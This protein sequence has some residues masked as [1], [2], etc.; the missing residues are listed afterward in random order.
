MWNAAD[1]T[2]SRTGRFSCP[3]LLFAATL[4]TSTPSFAAKYGGIDVGS[5]GIK[6][7]VVDVDGRKATIIKGSEKS[8]N[9]GLAGAL[10]QDG[11]TKIFEQGTLNEAVDVI[12]GHI[13]AMKKAPFSV[14]KVYVAVSSGLA[15]T[16]GRTA[17]KQLLDHLN[18]AQLDGVAAEI[19]AIPSDKE[20]YLTYKAIAA[21]VKEGQG[22]AFVIDVGGGNTKLATGD[23]GGDAVD[24][25]ATSLG[26][27]LD[28]PAA[29]QAAVLADVEATIQQKLEKFQSLKNVK[30][31]YLSGGPAYMITSLLDSD[32]LV[33]STTGFHVIKLNAFKE[34]VKAIQDATNLEDL[35]DKA[36][37]STKTPEGRQS[38]EK[39]K[40]YTLSQLKAGAYLLDTVVS[41]AGARAGDAIL[42]FYVDGQTAWIRQFVAQQASGPAHVDSDEVQLLKKQMPPQQNLWVNSGSG[43]LPSW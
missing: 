3:L 32:N 8:E 14:E 19:V 20:A 24:L 36:R 30:V 5:K 34:Q 2:L 15:D 22:A 11:E 26:K 27:A 10:T 9:L 43:R 23:E 35:F 13:A 33:K 17:L 18:G 7:V 25:G 12:K 4:L 31:I 42:K 21:V 1:F 16:A 40:I 37:A 39:A 28:V 41:K 29:Q 6:R 38:L